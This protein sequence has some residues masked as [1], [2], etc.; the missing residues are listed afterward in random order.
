MNIRKSI[1]LVLIACMVSGNICFAEDINLKPNIN[2]P[3]IKVDLPK[4]K[5][6]AK[7]MKEQQKEAA[8][9]EKALQ[10]AQK[11]EAFTKLENMA[12]AG[13]V[14][15]MYILAH[16]Y[17]TGQQVEENDTLAVNWWK[18]AADA[19]YPDADAWIGLSFAE[20]FGGSPQNQVSADRRYERAV[21]RGSSYGAIIL[22][23]EKYRKNDIDNKN[24]AIFLFEKA[25]SQG[26]PLAEQFLK[27]IR[28]KGTD[29]N[30]DFRNRIDWKKEMKK[31]PLDEMYY[32]AGINAYT[33]NIVQKDNSV[34][35][36]W[37]E[38]ATEAIYDELDQ[39]QEIHDGGKCITAFK[40]ND[41]GTIKEA[42]SANGVKN[43]YGYDTDKNLTS[44][45]INFNGEVLAQNRY[46]YDRNGNRTEKQQLRGTTYYTYDSI[47]QLINVK[48]PD[49]EEQLFYDKAGNRSK[50]I[51]ND[52]TEHYLYDKR[53]RLIRQVFQQPTGTTA[54]H[55]IY[56]NA[57]NLMNDGER[58]YKND[59]FNRVTRVETTTGQVQ[60]NRYDAEG[61]RY[62]MEENKKLVQFIFNE[63]REVVVEKS[64]DNL[65]RLIRSYDLWASEA[66]PEKTWYHYASDEQ[67]STIFITD[68]NKI[69]NKY[70][71]DAWGN[72]TTCEEILSNRFLYTGQQFDQ[73]TQQYYLRARYYNP[74]IARFTK[75]DVYRGDGLNLYTYCDNNPVIYY[76]PSGYS[77][78]S[79]DNKKDIY[80]KYIQV[81]KEN[82]SLTAAG[83]YAKISKKNPLKIH[84]GQKISDNKIKPDLNTG[85][86]YGASDPSVIIEKKWTLRD[87]KEALYGYSPKD[88]GNP[89]IHHGG[90]MPGAAKHE[91]SQPVVKNHRRNPALHLNKYN[92]GV[93]STMREEDRK[94]HWWYRAREEG[95]DI[96]F[97]DKIYDD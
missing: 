83:S 38:L 7:M 3:G 18:K 92:Q 34:A 74:V 79:C 10:E 37:W 50:R 40:Y 36:R 86:G 87:M 64:V 31:I 25:R 47:N 24:E 95:A 90:Q 94:L 75:E 11:K 39:L 84:L 60:I 15:S 71:Y 13:E 23:I 33:G 20:G 88:L 28:E 30:Q 42:V 96:L 49:Y 73:I 32:I 89:D 69:C 35:V 19:L 41:D 48:Y 62:E 52:V 61:L 59:A 8:K 78:K 44:L 65:K 56:D 29:T 26:N 1:S 76:D 85:V 77:I 17:Y 72:L 54:K 4:T 57:G 5:E 2:L 91:I 6:E 66:E 46:A 43:L 12:N 22:G 51:V 53:N 97:P 58:I 67:G 93:T 21:E 82:P 16:A 80:E 45:S 14:Q 55:Y 70:D 9:E 63:N 27:S 81:R 68:N